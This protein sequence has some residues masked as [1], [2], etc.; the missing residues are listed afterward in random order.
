MNKHMNLYV[1][2]YIYIYIFTY[3]FSIEIARIASLQLNELEIQSKIL[4]NHLNKDLANKDFISQKYI[5][6]RLNIE[7]QTQN[8][9]MKIKTYLTVDNQFENE[10]NKPH[11]LENKS[12][13]PHQIDSE[14]NKPHQ[15]ENKPHQFKNDF[16]KPHQLDNNP[17]KPHQEKFQFIDNL[18]E[19][20]KKYK[21]Q[22]DLHS[23]DMD[24]KVLNYENEISLL[25]NT[26]DDLTVELEKQINLNEIQQNNSLAIFEG[27]KEYTLECITKSCDQERNLKVVNDS[28]LRYACRA[29]EAEG[30][31]YVYIHIYVYYI[32]SSSSSS[33]SSPRINN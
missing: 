11:Q 19:I 30:G 3:I 12:N 10:S 13:E 28:L 14:S 4:V 16:S 7:M 22:V 1:Y 33:S 6:D 15:L 18:Y 32:K 23:N 9:Q 5:S 17:S 29:E 8:I 21:N 27:I 25:K 24:L 2:I 26:V 31:L 20:L